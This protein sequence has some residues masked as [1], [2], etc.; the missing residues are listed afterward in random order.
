MKKTNDRSH[1]VPF[2]VMDDQ[3]SMLLKKIFCSF[4]NLQLLGWKIAIQ[5]GTRSLKFSSRTK[6]NQVQTL[7]TVNDFLLSNLFT[8]H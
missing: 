8:I 4:F 2:F 5:E 1:E 6:V 7:R 3:T